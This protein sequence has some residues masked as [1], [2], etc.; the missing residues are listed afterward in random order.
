MKQGIVVCTWSGGQEACEILLKSIWNVP[1]PVLIVINDVKNMP[2]DWWKKL[3]AMTGEQNWHIYEQEH[4]G[5]ELGA[6][7]AA[8]QHTDWDEFFLLQDTF[9]VLNKDIFRILFEDYRERSVTY[10]PYKQMYLIKFRREILEKMEIPE[11]REKLESIRQ[12]EVFTTAYGNLEPNM[13]CF[14]PAFKDDAFYGNYEERFGRRNLVMRDQY[15]IK[16]K[17][18]WTAL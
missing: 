9:E 10:N 12:E 8:L 2:L 1:Y 6:I 15:L 7:K 14:N 11:V 3:Y 13:H 17:G 18:T 16:R 4:D 5:F